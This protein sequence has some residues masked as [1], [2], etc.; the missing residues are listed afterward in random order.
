MLAKLN[1]CSHSLYVWCGNRW[2]QEFEMIGAKQID[3]ETTLDAWGTYGAYTKL[4]SWYH[5]D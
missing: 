3:K 4:I 2:D 1:A 5:K